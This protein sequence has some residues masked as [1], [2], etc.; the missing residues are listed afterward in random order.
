MSKRL[1]I[2]C[3]APQNQPYV[4]VAAR[5]IRVLASKELEHNLKT[6]LQVNELLFR[7]PHVMHD[8]AK[9]SITPGDAQVAAAM[10]QNIDFEQYRV[11]FECLLILAHF[12]LYHTH[13]TGVR[14][15]TPGC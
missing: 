3:H 11:N 7:L 5:H 1:F 2:L 8:V 4:P 6:L 14:G 12:F 10:D 13:V 9:V 15:H